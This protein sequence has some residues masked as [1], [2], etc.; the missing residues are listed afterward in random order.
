MRSRAYGNTSS[1]DCCADRCAT[2]CCTAD[3]C[4]TN[5]RA[6]DRRFFVVVIRRIVR[7]FIV[8]IVSSRYSDSDK[9]RRNQYAW[10]NQ[11]PRADGNAAGTASDRRAWCVEGSVLACL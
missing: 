11:H 8:F 7:G 10:G 4:A 3:R 5:S 6:T 9:A 2:Y 1:T